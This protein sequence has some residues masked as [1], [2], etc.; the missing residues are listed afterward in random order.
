MR[1]KTKYEV[2][3][4]ELRT[5]FDKANL[6]EVV[7]FEPLGAGMYNAVYRV[8]T[9]D[10]TYAIK[11]A[12]H[13]S[14]KAMTYEQNMLNTEVL[15]YQTMSE[16]TS[17]DV[18]RIHYV[19]LSCSIIPSEY[20]IMDYI[21]GKTV[22][23]LKQNK[24]EKAYIK[25]NLCKSIAQIHSV[26]SDKFGYIQ[27]GLY[28]NWY[29]ALRSFVVNCLSDLSALGKKSKRGERLLSYIDKNRAL[30]ESVKG[31]LVN[32]DAWDLNIVANR[33]EKG[34]KLTWID[35]ERGFYGDSVFDFI[36][37]EA[38]SMSLARK[39]KSI[40]IYNKFSQDEL[41]VDSN[42]ETR[43]AFALGYMALIQETE[44]F[45]RFRRIDIGWW[46]DVFSSKLYYSKC[47]KLLKLHSQTGV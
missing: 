34:L 23:R 9:Q 16:K 24:Q 41:V 6:P 5:A 33:S 27:N 22:D 32:Y 43:F 7:S 11:I 10:G 12:P 20:F 26:K 30:L 18:P 25:E 35:P 38:M 1:S 3:I 46:F 37:I 44:K 45:Y 8:S 42:T 36:C 21:D 28:D 40:N 29:E 13:Q 14:V 39:Q 15:W 31:S 2:N 19:D 47:F 17:I 4:T